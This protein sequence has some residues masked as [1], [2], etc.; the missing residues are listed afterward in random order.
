MSDDNQQDEAAAPQLPWRQRV[1][2]WWRRHVGRYPNERAWWLPWR[3]AYWLGDR[4]VW[5]WAEIVAYKL[6]AGE[7]PRRNVHCAIR[8]LADQRRRGEPERLTCYCGFWDRVADGR[9]YTMH[10]EKPDPNAPTFDE[11]VP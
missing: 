2:I 5:C 4:H 3:V 7:R 6:D 1:R 8:E 10:N 11:A 9:L